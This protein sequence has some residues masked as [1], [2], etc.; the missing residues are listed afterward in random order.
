MHLILYL[1]F[2]FSILLL[3]DIRIC[4]KDL[5]QLSHVTI[6]FKVSPRSPASFRSN[7]QKSLVLAV[8]AGPSSCFWKQVPLCSYYAFKFYGSFLNY[9]L[10]SKNVKLRGKVGKDHTK[11]QHCSAACVCLSIVLMCMAIPLHLSAL[12][13]CGPDPAACWESH[14]RCSACCNKRPRIVPYKSQTL[15]DPNE[16]KK[17]RREERKRQ[18]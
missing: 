8:F 7:L 6:Y 2:P 10:I 16:R 4:N 3:D 9:M 11:S 17:G 15:Q 1:T 13:E 12:Y 14:Q 5:L 18:W